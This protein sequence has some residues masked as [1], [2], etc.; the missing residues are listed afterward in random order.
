M[1]KTQILF[2]ILKYALYNIIIHIHVHDFNT[3]ILNIRVCMC[4]YTYLMFHNSNIKRNIYNKILAD[5][6]KITIRTRVE[7]T[8]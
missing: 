7:E 2:I 1:Y 3:Y 8:H 6:Q 4:M 5:R